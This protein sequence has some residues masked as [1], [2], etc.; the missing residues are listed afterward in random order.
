MVCWC[1]SNCF[2]I[3]CDKVGFC[4]PE[5]LGSTVVAGSALGVIGNI[6]RWGDTN[7]IQVRSSETIFELCFCPSRQTF[8][9]KKAIEA[10]E[11][12]LFKYTNL[13]SGFTLF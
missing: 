1:F 10:P 2:R 9:N 6:A 5:I 12:L 4:P 3:D 11:F 8:E 7:Q 13:C